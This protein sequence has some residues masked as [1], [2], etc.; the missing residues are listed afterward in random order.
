[1]MKLLKILY[2]I[3]NVIII[4]A[5]LYVHFI[6]KER[7]YIDA[8]RYYMFPLPVIIGIILC[9]TIFL[10][11][12]R[13]NLMLAGILLV[14]WLGRSFKIHITETVKESDVE[15]VFWNASRDN[16]FEQAFKENINIPDVLV[17]VESKPNNLKHFRLKYPDYYFCS[18]SRIDRSICYL[19]NH[20]Q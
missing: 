16:G 3:V 7:S 15:V 12:R 6:L 11:K 17:L 20:R 8:L 14:V 19:Q 9:L 10:S 2:W 18:C 4:S 1:M 5:L 13:Y